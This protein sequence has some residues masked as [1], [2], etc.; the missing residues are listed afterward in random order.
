MN[1]KSGGA[2]MG[3][4]NTFN[5]W[6]SK[7]NPDERE[8]LNRIKSDDKEIK[9]RFSCPLEFGT[10]GMRGIIGTGIFRMN[11]YTVR[12]ATLGLGLYIGSL[13]AKARESGVVIAYDTRRFS[14]EFALE[15]AKVLAANGIN[16]YLYE[17]V[18]PVPICSFAI[19]H[20][21]AS[22]GIMITASHNPKE[23]N[24]YKVYGADGAQMSPEATAEVVKYIDAIK[25]YFEIKTEK[26]NISHSEIKGKD[27]VLIAPQIK[28][29]GESVDKEYYDTIYSQCLSLDAVERERANIK[30]V[31]TPLHGAG[32]KPVMR[33]L[34]RM[35]LPVKVVSAQVAPDPDFSTVSAPNP[36]NADALKLAIELALEEN[37]DV[38][39]G[40]D[41]DSDRMGA[42]LREGDEFLILNGNQIGALLM[43]YILSR[44]SGKGILP[45]NA[46]VVKTIVTTSLAAKIANSYGVKIYD[47]L[48]G[49]KF[50][51]EKIKE[52]EQD[53]THTFI[54]GYEESFG[55]LAGTHSRD[56]DA[57]VSS[58][59]FAE[60][61]AYNMS[62]GSSVAKRLKELY[63]KFGYYYEK[64]IAITY[65]GLDG[66][67]RMNEIMTSLRNTEFD[68][69]AGLKVE[70]F[71]DYLSSVTLY[72]DGGKTE[73][74]LPKSNV[75]YYGLTGGDWVCVRPS[76]TEPKL[77]VYVSACA[78]SRQSALNKAD[79]IIE[80][81]KARL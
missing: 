62:I 2:E 51:G 70:F 13:G 14:F 57:V 18:R 16:A 67:T 75:L 15:A 21:G 39:I 28:V 3:Y 30:I 5:E 53:G 77:K 1:K 59:L 34:D 10:A 19:R 33:I 35:G 74:L 11:V 60:M 49:F 50:I 40:T 76:G 66:M 20:L 22:A 48:T 64:N 37:M 29:I 43:D 32:Y 47:V 17:D 6:L 24:G 81:M 69:I 73:I 8:E 78:K 9:E 38:V 72:P 68:T 55:Y 4:I 25:D 31:Y 41:P 58:M 46:A 45:D 7:V 56:K 54:F 80:F 27:G 71:S 42:A 52:W 63:E 36:E 23:Y 26:V 61:V 65:Q 12:R 44:K 79:K